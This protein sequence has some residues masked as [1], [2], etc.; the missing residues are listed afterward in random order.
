PSSETRSRKPESLT[1]DFFFQAEDGIRAFHVTGVQT[2][3]LPICFIVFITLHVIASLLR[4]RETY[5]RGVLWRSW[6]N[7]ASSSLMDVAIWRKLRMYDR[8]GFHPDDID[9][10]ELVERWREELFGKDGSLN[11]LLVTAKGA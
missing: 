11:A 3:A 7:F 10:D 5:R 8:P 4:D 9:T 6:R 1:S 2:C